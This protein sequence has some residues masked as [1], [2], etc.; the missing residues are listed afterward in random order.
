MTKFQMMFLFFSVLFLTV[1]ICFLISQYF[2]TKA[3]ANRAM[4]KR[5]ME[6]KIVDRLEQQRRKQETEQKV[7]NL[8]NDLKI[9]ASRRNRN[10]G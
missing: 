5:E 9:Y 10:I 7:V 6:A 2:I 8:N 3:I 1:K 4:K